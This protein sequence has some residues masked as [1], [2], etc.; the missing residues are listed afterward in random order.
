M[1]VSV[2]TTE[3]LERR[4]TVE[5]P[6]E[7]ISEEVDNR[8]KRL[9]RTTR[10]KGFRPGK[11]PLKVVKQRYEGEVRQE[12]LG[13]VMQSTYYEAVA[14]EN[15]RPAG[16]PNIEPKNLEPG[17]NLEYVATFE[18]FPEITPASLEGTEFEKVTASVGD[19]DVDKVIENL[20]KQRMQWEEVDRASKEGDRVVADFKG[21]ID[22]EPFKGGEGKDVP[23][24]LGSGSMIPGF[25][26]GLTG[27]KGGEEKTIKVTFPEDYGHDEVAGKDAEFAV[28]V[29]KVEEGQL[30]EV[31]EEFAKAFGIG[32]GSVESLREEVRKNMERELD[33]TLRAQ[34]KQGVMDKLIE[35]N[36]VDV[37]KSLIDSESR[38][39]MD[40][41]RQ[42][43][44]IP[45]GKS[46]VDLDPS[47]FADQAER[48]VKLGLILSEII[49]TNELK[50][51]PE[52]VREQVEKLAASYEQPEQVVKWYYDDKNRLAEV[53]SLVLEDSV[54]DW[55]FGQGKVNEVQRSFDEVMNP[56]KAA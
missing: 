38:T 24:T 23:I 50:A 36:S 7:R 35:V 11:V 48:R 19:E 54:V 37:P 8:L 53:E 33:Q 56:E 14:K 42:Q 9:A 34:N 51:T 44:H 29:K 25:E 2:E 32:D 27:V 16:M 18:V 47:M 26:E 15:L 20:R 13:E 46:G 21:S 55:A 43:M 6:E 28:T 3:G 30:P 10:M 5:V 17:K 22:G 41:M 40:Q 45:E 39:L 49:K 52:A 12:V 4:M 31:D 1:Q